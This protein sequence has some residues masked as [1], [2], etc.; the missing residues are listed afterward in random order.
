MTLPETLHEKG[1]DYELNAL[2]H[3][4]RGDRESVI[5]FLAAALVFHELANILE[6]AH[7][8]LDAAA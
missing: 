8:E 7:A 1:R 5:G 4:D 6:A 2:A 3:G